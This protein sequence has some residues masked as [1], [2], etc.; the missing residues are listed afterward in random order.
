MFHGFYNSLSIVADNKFA[1]RS[2][3]VAADAGK[4]VILCLAGAHVSYELIM[5]HVHTSNSL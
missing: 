5:L 2:R 4:T 3:D 1:R